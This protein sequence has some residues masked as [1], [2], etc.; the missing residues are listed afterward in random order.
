M[1]QQAILNIVSTILFKTSIKDAK[2]KYTIQRTKMN[3]QIKIMFE[4]IV[5]IKI[6]LFPLFDNLII[7]SSFYFV[8]PFLK[9]FLSR[10]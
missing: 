10:N 1:S 7:S 8:K 3:K 5:A 4:I 2:I 9:I 6:N